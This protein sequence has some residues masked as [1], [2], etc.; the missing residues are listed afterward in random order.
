MATATKSQKSRKAKL[1]AK[2]KHPMTVEIIVPAFVPL[3]AASSLDVQKLSKGSHTIE[4]GF[5]E[6][7][8]CPKLVRAV[9][10]NGVVSRL[11]VESCED[12]ERVMPR[13]MSRDIAA[14]VSKAQKL[15]TKYP[16]KPVPVKEFVGSIA[17]Q[18]GSYPPRAGWGAGCFYICLG[19]Y[20]IFC[21]YWNLPFFCWIER[22]KPDVEM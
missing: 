9:I 17:Q 19:Y 7:G 5:L 20:C 1:V 12:S 6:G 11:D 4:I 3:A 18:T 13:E 22:R 16:W 21:C 8:C 14:I 15:A 2:F 10:R